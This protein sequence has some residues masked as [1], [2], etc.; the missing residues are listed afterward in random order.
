MANAPYRCFIVMQLVL[1]QP[2]MQPFD[3]MSDVRVV[4]ACEDVTA[5]QLAC[6]LLDFVGR[7]CGPDGRLIYRWW[8]FEVLAFSSLRELA[9]HET[10]AADVIIIAARE[11]GQFPPE[12]GNWMARWLELRDGRGG[13]LV[14]LLES[15]P[16]P[17]AA[18]GDPNEVFALL[19]TAAML[20]HLDYIIGRSDPRSEWGEE[21]FFNAATRRM[22]LTSI[23]QIR[24]RENWKTSVPRSLPSL[25]PCLPGLPPNLKSAINP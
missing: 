13:A 3:P 25:R 2:W 12:I 11:S 24:R 9:S 4:I 8:N 17:T 5:A 14:I 20:G 21:V 10:V 19:Q 15:D 6:A 1:D 7:D 18:S 16:L 23:T 22:I